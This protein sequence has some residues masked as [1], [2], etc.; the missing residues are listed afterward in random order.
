MSAVLSNEIRVVAIDDLDRQIVSLSTRINAETYELLVLIRQFDERA[1][2]LKWGFLN[3]TEWLHCPAPP[4]GPGAHPCVPFRFLSVQ[5]CLIIPLEN[6][7]FW[8]KARRSGQQNN[9]QQ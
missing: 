2:W 1:G 5:T 7:L 8:Q 6:P 9:D 3:C 4:F